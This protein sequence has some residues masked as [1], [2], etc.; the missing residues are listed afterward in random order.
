MSDTKDLTQLGQGKT[1]YPTR[2]EDAILE[3][4]ENQNLDNLY[5]VPFICNEFTSLCPKTG[6]PDF[7]RFEIIYVPRVR[8]IESK[9]LKLY[10][11]SF[12]NNGEFHE[13][14]TNRIFKDLWK[15]M[16]PLFM[17]IVGDFTVRGGIAIKPLVMKYADELTD[18]NNTKDAF[19]VDKM[20]E[21][22]DRTKSTLQ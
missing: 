22:W 6:Q 10:L 11:F 2:P 9:A 3:T 18:V 20:I 12:R 8:M 16:D 5:L 14:V 7:A 21:N 13:D 1:K 4:F 19:L 17:R 15:A